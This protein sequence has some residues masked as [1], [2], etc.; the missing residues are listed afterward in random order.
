MTIALT[1]VLMLLYLPSY[2]ASKD[3]TGAIAANQ[4]IDK[5]CKNSLLYSG[6]G[7]D[8]GDT[9]QYDRAATPSVAKT[10]F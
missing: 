8:L 2:T 7:S 5:F 4:T 6:N 3:R 9:A 1:A 10:S